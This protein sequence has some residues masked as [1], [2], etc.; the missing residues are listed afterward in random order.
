MRQGP[1]GGIFSLKPRVLLEPVTAMELTG[2]NNRQAL[3]GGDFRIGAAAFHSMDLRSTVMRSV[4][5]LWRLRIP[6]DARLYALDVSYELVGANG[7]SSRLCSLNKSGSEIKVIID[8]IPPR[9]V[10]RDAHSTVIEGGMVMHLQ[11]ELARSAGT[12]SGTL[13]VVVNHF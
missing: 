12:Y 11:L 7:R 5:E 9:V 1:T 4:P 13:T 3:P 8:E 10:G 2:C 6:Q